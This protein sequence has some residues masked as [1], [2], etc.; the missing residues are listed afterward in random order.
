MFR[1]IVKPLIFGFLGGIFGIFLLNIVIPKSL[2]P[3]AA[4]S[5]FQSSSPIRVLEEVNFDIEKARKILLTLHQG[6]LPEGVV[7]AVSGYA[8]TLTSD[9][10]VG[11]PDTIRAPMKLKAISNDRHIFTIKEALNAKGKPFYLPELSISFYNI[12]GEQSSSV[13]PFSISAYEQV[14]VGES[15]FKFSEDGAISIY[16]V[17]ATYT[18]RTGGAVES[19]EDIPPS[20][21]IDGNPSLGHF[22]FNHKGQLTGIS[23][24]N[25]AVVSSEFIQK[26]LRQYLDNQEYHPTLLGINFM[27][28]NRTVPLPGEPTFGLLLK[29]A[30]GR[31]AVLPK[32]PAAQAG[33]K[34]G[35]VL[36]SFDR[37][38]LD[39]AIPFQLLLQRYPQDAEVELG[40]IREGKEQTVSVVLGAQP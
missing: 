38:R 25:G 18:S 11:I 16:R 36:I 27:D 2:F 10:L 35:D 28:L 15:L 14:K 22:L 12:L 8:L 34:E 26:A 9:G 5:R 7:S 30:K 4:P 33:L 39:S 37:R 32:S 20:F 3:G 23:S 19:S 6:R 17:I 40:I 24:E 29:G 1:N 13:S 21:F 31:P